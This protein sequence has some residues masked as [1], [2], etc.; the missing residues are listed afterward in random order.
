MG[1]HE[2]AA[3][4]VAIEK[5]ERTDGLVKV[6]PRDVSL[7]NEIHLVLTNLFQPE[8]LR[9]LAEV[10]GEVSDVSDVGVYGAHRPVAHT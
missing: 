3:Q 4:R 9:R 5:L 10:A 7:M 2:V 8:Q 1:D 6:T